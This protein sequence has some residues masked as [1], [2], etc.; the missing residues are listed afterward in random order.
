MAR[1]IGEKLGFE[2]ITFE[3]YSRWIEKFKGGGYG[4]VIGAV[5]LR[6]V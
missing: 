1:I 5:R 4:G 3:F 2:D 6:Y